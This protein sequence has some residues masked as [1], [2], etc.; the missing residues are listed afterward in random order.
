M[1]PVIESYVDLN[2]R[3]LSLGR[4]IKLTQ[5]RP[6]TGY[7]EHP[8]PMPV[9]TQVAISTDEGVSFEAVVTQVH[10]QVGGSD[11]TPGMTVRPQL[12][13]DRA[14]SWWVARVALPEQ[15]EKPAPR[16]KPITV[17]PRTH[18]VPDPAPRPAT[19]PPVPA[20]ALRPQVINAEYV[21]EIPPKITAD[22]T[23][24]MHAVVDQSK[25]MTIEAANESPNVAPN[26][27]IDDGKKTTVM[28]AV[29]PELLAMLGA[30]STT[31]ELP[32]VD[33]GKQTTVMESVDVSALGLDV[34]ASGS[35]PTENGD[36]EI[37]G[38]SDGPAERA[39][40]NGDSDKPAG[41]SGAVKRRKKRR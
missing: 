22:I 41:K 36:D 28:E 30:R 23:T 20:A 24:P 11:R 19:P 15:E 32:V 21:V 13:D 39:T 8:T 31:G 29:D 40:T 1:T 35:F 38:A 34:S 6:T 2:Y 12:A 10:E 7:L 18:T 37:S 4:R 14:S 27:I 3:G 17:R 25:E 26:E 16:I 33:D 5:V 9:G